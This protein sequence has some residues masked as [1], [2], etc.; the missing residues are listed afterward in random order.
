MDFQLFSL[1]H[2]HFITRFVG[3]TAFMTVRSVIRPN[4]RL[5]LPLRGDRTTPNLHTLQ[6]HYVGNLLITN[7][8]HASTVVAGFIPVLPTADKIQSKFPAAARV[9]INP[10]PTVAECCKCLSI[11]GLRSFLDSVA[12][13]GNK[14][15]DSVWQPTGRPRGPHPQAD[16]GDKG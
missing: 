8:L 5:P 10:T 2:P 3:W 15:R 4:T 13:V 14:Y 16:H 6:G 11:R 12:I 1:H 9:G 7:V